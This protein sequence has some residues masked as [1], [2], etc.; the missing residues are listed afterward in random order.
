[1]KTPKSPKRPMSP[2]K[3]KAVVQQLID[4]GEFP[5]G[6][7]KERSRAHQPKQ[8]ARILVA[9][10]KIK[11]ADHALAVL[12]QMARFLGREVREKSSDK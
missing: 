2:E 8:V 7:K 3:R 6:K 11:G 9:R 5:R 1:V 4:T 12:E 10:L